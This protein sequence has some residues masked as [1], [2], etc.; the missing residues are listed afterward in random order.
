MSTS[1]QDHPSTRRL[2]ERRA[3]HERVGVDVV[4]P[5]GTVVIDVYEY[6]PPRGDYFLRF[7][8]SEWDEIV[9]A[10]EERRREILARIRK[11]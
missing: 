2:W 7:S 11:T 4:G 6:S 3:E 1:H 5:D 8:A 9:K 10:V